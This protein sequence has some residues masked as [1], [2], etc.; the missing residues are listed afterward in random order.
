M[1]KIVSYIVTIAVIFMI[2]LQM[3]AQQPTRN[4]STSTVGLELH[5]KHNGN[6][7]DDKQVISGI[8]TDDN[9]NSVPYAGIRIKNKRTAI[10]S[11]SN[12]Y[13]VIPYDK[14]LNTD[15]ISI[16][17]LGYTTRDIPVSE[18]S[19]SADM[20][21]RLSPAI[22]ELN[23]VLAEGVDGRI[24]TKGKTHGWGCIKGYIGGET[25][26][27]CFGYEFHSA[28]GK[29]LALNTVGFYYCEG[30]SQM[31]DMKFRI[32]IYDMGAVR[33]SPTD[34]FVSVNSRPIFVE[35]EN[36]NQ[37]K[38]KF[39]YSLPAPIVLPKDAMVEIEFL[40]NLGGKK[41]WYRSN[42]IA[43]KT[44]AKY[45]GNAW[46]I[47]DPFASPFYVSCLEIEESKQI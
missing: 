2:V 11:D 42:I 1:I 30:D 4:F 13:F 14:I 35:Y 25:A 15:T 3:V 28:K 36:K 32:N 12:G 20:V 38:G 22:I 46:W 37:K 43:K 33:E 16:S 24:V 27:A 44:W 5:R 7:G 19:K 21:V 40:E 29:L 41:L 9:S 23:E 10:L 45:S 31:T 34:K 39:E 47:L 6:A 8:V 17:C 26:G 18:F